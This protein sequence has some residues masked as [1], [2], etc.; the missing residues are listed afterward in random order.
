VYRPVGCGD[1][2]K[3]FG[4]TLKYR[5]DSACEWGRHTDKL[6]KT[7]DISPKED[8]TLPTVTGAVGS[9]KSHFL[10]S[11]L[12][13]M[14]EHC[15]DESLQELL[16]P[17]H[18]PLQLNVTF[19]SSTQY[20]RLEE[21]A[22]IERA[23]VRRLLFVYFDINWASVCLLE[24]PAK[25]GVAH[26]VDFIVRHHRE[27]H[28]LPADQEIFVFIGVDEVNQLVDRTNPRNE[29]EVVH[30]LICTVRRVL[31]NQSAN[32]CFVA[33]LLAGTHDAVIRSA[34]N[35]SGIEPKPISLTPFTHD[36]I[37]EILRTEADL[38]EEYFSSDEFM[39]VVTGCGGE[40]RAIGIMVS[41]LHHKYDPESIWTAELAVNEYFRTKV[42][43][44]LSREESDILSA[45]LVTGMPYHPMQN[46]VSEDLTLQ[47]LQDDGLLSLRPSAFTGVYL[48]AQVDIPL[49]LLESHDT[50]LQSILMLDAR[51]LIG[52]CRGDMSGR[53]FEQNVG[54]YIC[55]KRNALRMLVKHN[56]IRT[57]YIPLAMFFNGAIVSK[58]ISTTELL[59]KTKFSEYMQDDSRGRFPEQSESNNASEIVSFLQQNGVFVNTPGAKIDLITLD[60]AKDK[61]KEG[62]YVC[63]EIVSVF[64]VIHTTMGATPLTTKKV[65]EDREK[66]LCALKESSS[67]KDL[68]SV[69]VHITTGPFAADLWKELSPNRSKNFTTN[70]KY[71]RSV[72]VGREQLSSVFG[73]CFGRL[74][75][76]ATPISRSPSTMSDRKYTTWSTFPR[77]GMAGLRT[78]PLLVSLMK[79]VCKI[80]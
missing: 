67:L 22:D 60:Q 48:E 70:E 55:L 20:V 1:E 31:G 7:S 79:A 9:G 30:N 66:V 5:D 29:G 47:D 62:M 80:R 10:S 28:C 77:R 69:M 50:F 41:E 75:T 12:E 51:K 26:C 11:S 46:L 78:K 39:T 16:K 33:V 4:H 3:G 38:P 74:L 25:F 35:I 76:A 53:L 36:Q 24:V 57:S 59:I 23:L 8:K 58:D 52:K 72:F 56:I 14:R 68:R 32:N 45:L 6:R 43:R 19:S 73:P 65:A 21:A 2:V 34:F 13:I 37:L 44:P 63:D 40:L 54:R 15:A 42:P 61:D 18:H 17:E 64:E 71:P 27:Q 49:M